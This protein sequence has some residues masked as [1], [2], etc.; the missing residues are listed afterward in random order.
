MAGDVVRFW[1]DFMLARP[2]R[3][4]A[5]LA[6]ITAPPADFV[7]E[8]VHGHP[9]VGVRRLL[10]RATSTRA[11]GCS[12]RCASSVR[13]AID[14][15]GPMPYIAVQELIEP[16]RTRTGMRNYW[17]ADF[18]AELPDEAIDVLVAHATKPVSP[19]SARSCSSPAAARSR[20]CPR[21]RPRSAS[22][23]AVQHPL[24]V[25]VG[26]P[27]R[28]RRR[29]SRTRASMAARDEAVDDRPRV[30]Q[31]HRRRR[32]RTG[33]SRR[34][35]RRSTRACRRSRPSGTPTTSSATTRTSSPRN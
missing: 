31:L 22:A 16:R 4:A 8:P 30:P 11:S 24:P 12:R 34:S 19:M 25:D 14:L 17:T 23:R 26:R 20:A 29:T 27:G 28:R 21:T 32:A 10:R 15:V 33:S 35:A 6:F 7:P 1:R 5:A 3:W 13:P 9:V 2:T 18:F